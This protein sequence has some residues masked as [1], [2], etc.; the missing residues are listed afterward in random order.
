MRSRKEPVYLEE[1]ITRKGRISL[2]AGAVAFSEKANKL[3]KLLQKDLSFV[4]L[5]FVH[6]LRMATIFSVVSRR[7]WFFTLNGR[8]YPSFYHPFNE[9]WRNERAVELPVM[10]EEVER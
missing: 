10:R 4:Q 5:V 3:L 9:T 8:Q 7:P 2:R 6:K 1:L